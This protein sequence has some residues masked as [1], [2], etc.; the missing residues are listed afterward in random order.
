MDELVEG[1]LKIRLPKGA[2][3]KKLD[4]EVL[5]GLSHCMKA[6][7]FVVEFQDEIYFIEIK[8]PDNPKCPA[9]SRQEYL[10]RILSGGVDSDLKLK[11]RDSFLYEWAS[12]NITKPVRFLVL[13]GAEALSDAELLVRTEALKR[14]IPV[15]GPRKT[16]WK[17]SFISG[18]AVMNIASW[19]RIVKKMPVRRGA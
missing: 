13:I 2:V 17:N 15:T 14:L 10:K 1:D 6:V 19:N 12:G 3:G 18:C 7:D 11:Y 9:A 5:H 16:A 4:D 8:D